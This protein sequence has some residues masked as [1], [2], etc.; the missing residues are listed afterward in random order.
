MIIINT[1][2]VVTQ[3]AGSESKLCFVVLS[4]SLFGGDL[5]NP[6]NSSM[7]SICKMWHCPGAKACHANSPANMRSFC[8]VR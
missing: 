8:F 4:F 3:T 2:N 7:Y 1:E 6:S 5:D